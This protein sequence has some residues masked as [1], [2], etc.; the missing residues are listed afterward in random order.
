[1]FQMQEEQQREAN[2]QINDLSSQWGGGRN[3]WKKRT[4]Q[5]KCR[6]RQKHQETRNKSG[7]RERKSNRGSNQEGKNTRR[8]CHQTETS[9][10]KI[11]IRKRGTKK[12]NWGKKHKNIKY[13]QFITR[14]GHR[15]IIERRGTT[16]LTK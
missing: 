9:R 14:R 8:E 10:R 1:M 12:N 11:K 4:E 5:G 6:K 3:P 15:T 13:L 16:Q 7:N 2:P